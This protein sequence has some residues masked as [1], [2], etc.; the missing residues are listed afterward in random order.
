MCKNV[1]VWY[2]KICKSFSTAKF[3]AMLSVHQSV[4]LLVYLSVYSSISLSICL[5]ACAVSLCFCIWYLSPSLIV[6][7]VYIRVSSF[8]LR[9]SLNEFLFGPFRYRELSALGVFLNTSIIYAYYTPANNVGEW[10]TSGNTLSMHLSI[11]VG[12]FYPYLTCHHLQ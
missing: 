5:F 1:I 11:D 4:W 7:A 12:H 9:W 2:V 8:M 6:L 3:G 10:G